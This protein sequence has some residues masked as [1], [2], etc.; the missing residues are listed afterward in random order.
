MESPGAKS[1]L[2]DEG[3]QVLNGKEN[4]AFEPDN[5]DGYDELSPT[6]TS[7]VKRFVAVV[8][9]DDDDHSECGWF[10]IRPRLIQ[11]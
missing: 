11:V 3:E 2:P 5:G 7:D 10:D 9:D 1:E 6:S 4:D 8:D